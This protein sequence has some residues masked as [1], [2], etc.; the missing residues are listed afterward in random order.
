[1]SEN[2]TCPRAKEQKA[3]PRDDEA[4]KE[5]SCLMKQVN[6]QGIVSFY[7]LVYRNRS[8]TAEPVTARDAGGKDGA[9]RI[10]VLVT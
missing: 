6:E 5:C 3:A 1:M 10:K 7:C 9:S 2:W 8:G 4:C